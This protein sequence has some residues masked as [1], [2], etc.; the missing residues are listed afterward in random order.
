MHV[1]SQA[2]EDGVSASF[3]IGTQTGTCY[4]IDFFTCLGD[5]L[6]PWAL[7]QPACN[8]LLSHHSFVFLN[9]ILL[10]VY[11]YDIVF[12]LVH[13]LKSNQW[14]K[15]LI[16][17]IMHE[18]IPNIT[19]GQVCLQLLCQLPRPSNICIGAQY[20]VLKSSW[21]WESWA[22]DVGSCCT[23]LRVLLHGGM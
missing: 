9:D 14:C 5:K 7:C 3:C 6:C 8:I 15:T 4:S 17:L 19:V 16:I 12:M 10:L 18:P 11:C 22:F 21:I 23:F 1:T 2:K 20:F 13:M